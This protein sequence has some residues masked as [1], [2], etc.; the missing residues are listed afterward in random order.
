M[1]RY[2][3]DAFTVKNNGKYNLRWFTPGGEIELCGH[4]TLTTPYILMNYIDQNMKS[5]ILST[6]SSDLDVTRNDELKSVEVTDEMVDALGVT[7]KEVYLRRDL[8]CIF[9]NTE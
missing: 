7:P 1:K 2:V 6:L 5:V 9:R 8:L 4:A 3:V